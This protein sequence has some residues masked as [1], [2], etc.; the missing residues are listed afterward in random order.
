[1]IAT[2]TSGYRDFVTTGE[3][4]LVVPVGDIGALASA[5]ARLAADAD[6][7]AS[8]GRQARARAEDFDERVVL[9]RFARLIDELAGL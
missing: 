9:E 8:L 1:V 5:I 7:R 4:G 3:T 2:D 6:L